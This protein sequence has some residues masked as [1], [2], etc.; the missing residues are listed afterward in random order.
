MSTLLPLS[1]LFLLACSS[2]S[3]QVI[4]PE[5]LEEPAT[6]PSALPE[7]STSA[8]APTASVAAPTASVAAPEPAKACT[9]M[10]CLGLLDLRIE[11]APGKR[12]RY[13]VEVEADGMRGSCTMTLPYP[14]CGAPLSTCEGTLPVMA[15]EGD[16][17]K[18]PAAEQTLLPMILGVAPE[19]VTVRVTLDGKKLG[20][21]TATPVYES[22]R[23]NGP[24]C[25][26][27]CKK[28]TVTVVAGDKPPVRVSS[29]ADAAKVA[30]KC[31]KERKLRGVWKSELLV[32]KPQ[33][34][35]VDEDWSVFFSEKTPKGKPQGIT[36][37]VTPAGGCR[38]QPMD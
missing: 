31:V 3:A 20:E 35:K 1:L 32:D 29:D 9:K 13:V 30:S 11:S 7:P 15:R 23:P 24:G 34:L 8:A 2:S 27:V 21:Q 28:A 26:P 12:G 33:V 10:G 16:A 4:G 25:D 5:P 14:K 18:V 19:R 6:E 38:I 17:C 22:V 37:L 36:I